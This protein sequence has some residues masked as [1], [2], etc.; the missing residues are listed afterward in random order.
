MAVITLARQRN[1]VIGSSIFCTDA[2]RG[3][4]WWKSS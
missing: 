2:K 4:G 3:D 1:V